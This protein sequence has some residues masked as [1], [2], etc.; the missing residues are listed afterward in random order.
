MG[1]H[2]SPDRQQRGFTIQ[3]RRHMLHELRRLADTNDLVYERDLVA[4]W[5]PRLIR[6]GQVRRIERG[7]LQVMKS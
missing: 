4:W 2:A 7:V 5:I 1:R 6:S 3:D